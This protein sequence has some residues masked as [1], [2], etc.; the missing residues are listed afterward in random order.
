VCSSDL[1]LRMISQWQK[2]RSAFNHDWLKNQYMPALAKYLN[3]LDD[4]LED[5][6]FER[7]FILETLPEWEAHRAEALALARSFESE[8]SPQRLFDAPPLARCDEATKQWLGE[9]IHTLWLKRYPVRQWISGAVTATEHADTAYQK[10]HAMLRACPNVYSAEVTRPYRAQFG[11]LRA[12]C[13]DLA[14]A[15]S[16]FPSEV[17]VI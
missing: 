16:K 12:R 6:E 10:L 3:L 5:L 14:N 9:F 17:K 8:M 1:Q 2:D 11:E 7:S 4:Q 15:V 13:Q